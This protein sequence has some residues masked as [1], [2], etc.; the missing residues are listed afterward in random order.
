M[1]ES[2]HM[3]TGARKRQNSSRKQDDV[4]SV[5][6][7]PDLSGQCLEAWRS[8][9]DAFAEMQKALW[10]RTV[11]Y[12]EKTI[13]SQWEAAQALGSAKTPAEAARIQVALAPRTLE[14]C[15]DELAELIQ[16]TSDGMSAA[17]HPFRLRAS[18]LMTG[19]QPPTAAG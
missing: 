14:S 9:L 3:S 11:A 10:A 1:S 13:S 2:E 8:S 5:F 7:W 18:S 17:L 4:A 12:S 16:L 15:A 6:G 19:R